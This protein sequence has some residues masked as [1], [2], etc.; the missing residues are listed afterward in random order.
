MD[1]SYVQLGYVTNNF[2]QAVERMRQTHGLGPFK[3]MR[4]LTIGARDGQTVTAHFALA[5]KDGTQ[6]EIIHPLSGDAGFYADCLTA[7]GFA[8]HLH[9]IGHYYPALADYAAAKYEAKA[10]WRMPVEVAIFDGEYAYFDARAAFGHYLELYSFPPETHFEG[11]P[12]Y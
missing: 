4:D 12:R 7:H 6:F 2:D 11:V 10:R 8:M 9:H 1:K 3:E 5:F